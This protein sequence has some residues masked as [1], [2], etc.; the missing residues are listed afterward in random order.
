MW[1]YE[2]I[3]FDRWRRNVNSNDDREKDEEHGLN[4]SATGGGS[5]SD[6]VEEGVKNPKILLAYYVNALEALNV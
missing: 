1:E 5:I 3:S 2:C 6:K 4:M